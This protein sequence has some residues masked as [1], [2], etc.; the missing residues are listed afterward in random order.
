M[1]V[2]QISVR[3]LLA[4]GIVFAGGLAQAQQS[5][6]TVAKISGDVWISSGG[7]QKASL[8]GGSVVQAGDDLRTGRNGRVLLTRGEESILIAPNSALAIPQSTRDGLSTTITQRAGSALFE[9]EKRNVQHFS[10]ETPNLAAVVK[11]TQFR[12]TVT[13]AGS[14]VQ[15]TRGAVQVADFKTGQ[16]A[17][18]LPGQAARVSTSGHGGLQLSGPGAKNILQGTPRVP[19]VKAQKAQPAAQASNS[20]L[21]VE[22]GMATRISAPIGEVNLDFNKVTDGLARGNSASQG[23]ADGLSANAG[24]NGKDLRVSAE[25]G[26]AGNAGSVVVAVSVSGASSSGG[27]NASGGGGGGGASS[28]SSSSGSAGG[29]GPTG[30]SLV[31]GGGGGGGGGNGGSSSGLVGGLLKKTLGLLH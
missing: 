27:V 2:R 24:L 5:G 9:V 7:V 13:R 10:V 28:S 23:N 11:G 20:A 6:W 18:V 12:V 8:G 25:R 22:R 1:L 3:L 19:S 14:N 29:A 4:I 17:V 15:V 21:Q 30:A 16:Y 26:V 31:V